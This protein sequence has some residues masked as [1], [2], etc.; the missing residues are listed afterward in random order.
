MS[1][2]SSAV[3]L[4]S[5]QRHVVTLPSGGSLPVDQLAKALG[6]R[7][8]KDPLGLGIERPPAPP[9]PDQHNLEKENKEYCRSLLDEEERAQLDEELK[10]DKYLTIEE[11]REMISDQCPKPLEGAANFTCMDAELMMLLDQRTNY[12]IFVAGDNVF[13]REE[14]YEHYPFPEFGV[15]PEAMFSQQEIGVFPPKKYEMDEKKLEYLA[16]DVGDESVD[17]VML[18]DMVGQAARDNYKLQR[19]AVRIAKTKVYLAREEWDDFAHLQRV[20]RSSVRVAKA[21]IAYGGPGAKT[22]PLLAMFG[23][24]LA[25]A[26]PAPAAPMIT[27]TATHAAH[28]QVRA[29]HDAR[30]KQLQEETE[31]RSRKLREEADAR[32]AM[33]RQ[34]E[35]ETARRIAEDMRRIDERIAATTAA[36]KKRAEEMAAKAASRAEMPEFAGRG[37]MP[38]FGGRGG[39]PDFGGR[40]GMPD[41]GG[42]GR[43][44]GSPMARVADTAGG[45]TIVEEPESVSA[46]SSH[47]GAATSSTYNGPTISEDDDSVAL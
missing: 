19:K 21:Q 22:P 13:T 43:G 35:E 15:Q 8:N 27:D 34:R 38:D 42:R 46:S 10:G 24:G 2:S 4:T 23:F 45:P 44:R 31:A 11:V 33:F 9:D 32:A 5:S 47:N 26:P 29:Q 28:E 18:E 30:M 40:G 20:F 25:S 36:S 7:R 39:M 3:A 6:P 41:F 37:G 17:F 16:R 12:K 1:S 14:L